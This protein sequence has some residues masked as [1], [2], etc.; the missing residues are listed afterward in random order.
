MKCTILVAALLL[1]PVSAIAQ[2]ITDA[3]IAAIARRELSELLGI[4]GEPI[5][6]DSA[7]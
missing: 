7:T 1:L 2:G 6:A 3:E 5:F 4:Q